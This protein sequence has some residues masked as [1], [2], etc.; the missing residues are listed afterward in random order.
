MPRQEYSR[1][2]GATEL[3]EKNFLPPLTIAIYNLILKELEKS[4]NLMTRTDRKKLAA[5]IVIG[6]MN[7]SLDSVANKIEGLGRVKFPT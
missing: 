2:I 1:N 4:E 7:S 6:M 3:Y 5:I